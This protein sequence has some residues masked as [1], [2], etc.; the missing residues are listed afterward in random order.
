M[1]FTIK[2][3]LGLTFATIIVLSMVTAVLGINSLAS[4][5]SNLESLV[6][7]PVQRL[8]LAQE[9]FTDLLLV[10]RG[11]KNMVLAELDRGSRSAT[12]RTS[13]KL[14]QNSV[15]RLE[16]GDVDRQCRGQAEMGSDPHRL[17]AVRRR[18]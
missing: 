17:D 7:G 9:L 2:M 18:R 16:K 6:E 14:R 3:K 4:L 8:Q 1:R 5:D 11:E 12:T 13:R 10:V 15:T